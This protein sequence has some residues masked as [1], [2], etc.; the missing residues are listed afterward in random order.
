[1]DISTS[2]PKRSTGAHQ[3]GGASTK[4]NGAESVNGANSGDFDEATASMNANSSTPNTD[5]NDDRLS[6]SNNAPS[7]NSELNPEDSKKGRWKF[8]FF[9]IVLVLDD[10]LLSVLVLAP[11]LKFL[12][13]ARDENT[14]HYTVYRS[15]I[16]LAVLAAVRI[17]CIA[18]GLVAAFF[19]A[20][21]TPEY[22]FSLYHPNGDKKSREELE[23][24]ALEEAWLPWLWRSLT[25]YAFGT[26]LVA[27]VTQVWAVVKCL[28]RMDVEL[29]DWADK[30]PMHPLFWIAILLTTILAMLEAQWMETI[31]QMVA[32]CGK[33]YFSNRSATST[34]SN[35][36]RSLFRSISSTLSIPLLAGESQDDENNNAATD[37]VADTEDPVDERGTSDIGADAQSRATWNDLFLM[38]WPDMHWIV[39]AFVFLLLAAIAQV[40]I[41][42]YLGNILDALAEAF[43]GKDDDASR[44]KSMVEVPGFM[45]NMEL[46]VLASVGAGVFSGLRGSFFT[47]VGGR[48][49]IR[50]RVQLMDSLLSQ[51]IGFFDVTKTGDITSRLS[52]DTTL[53]GD[54]VTLNVN[55]FLRSLVQAAGVLIFMFVVSWQLSILAFISVPLITVLSKWYGNYGKFVLWFSKT[56]VLFAEEGCSHFLFSPLL[57]K[58]D[59]EEIGGWKCSLRSSLGI[60]GYRSDFRCRRGGTS[61][62][63]KAYGKLPQVQCES[64][65]QLFWI[66]RLH[67]SCASACLR[68]RCLLRRLY[69]P[70]W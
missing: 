37:S 67:D 25:R 55:V 26:E 22:P 21:E 30:E 11:T 9:G 18:L 64:C 39:A 41:P 61:R 42:R 33:S 20:K 15:L 66:L 10:I 54:Q 12:N 65:N 58:I 19:H 45:R 7:E 5:H 53:V 50:L 1:M 14:D 47:V 24:E 4:E 28:K 32:K 29:G 23:Q 34:G 63:R 48:V 60:N 17:G 38:C 70:K 40:L 35:S 6:S 49:N 52:S 62:I 57:D 36:P 43:D 68:D 31:C 3:R 8:W 51:D 2:S 13:R 27:L 46:L 56:D 16:D 44:H 69:G 59:A